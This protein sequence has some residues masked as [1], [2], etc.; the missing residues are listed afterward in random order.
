MSYGKL[1]YDSSLFLSPYRPLFFL[2]CRAYE[3]ILT[4]KAMGMGIVIYMDTFDVALEE[5]EVPI[6]HDI[7]YFPQNR[8]TKIHISGSSVHGIL[9]E[10]I[11]EWVAIPFSRG[12]SQP[13]DQTQVSCIAG[14]FFTWDIKE[15]L[16]NYKTCL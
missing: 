1:K 8:H 12:S 3:L 10:R 9:Q 11:L 14:R 4:I 5:K 15:A 16:A 6:Y 13:R 7:A 2:I